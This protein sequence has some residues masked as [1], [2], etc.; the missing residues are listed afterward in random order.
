MS[1]PLPLAGIGAVVRSP[2]ESMALSREV[3]RLT[4]GGGWR[5]AVADER[6]LVETIGGLLNQSA[7]DLLIVRYPTDCVLLT[8]ALASRADVDM[9][10]AGTLVYW[11]DRGPWAGSA[12]P[13]AS[14]LSS[15]FDVEEALSV[16]VD[17]FRDY[18]NHYSYNPQLP[19]K[20]TASGYL[21]W[22]RTRLGSGDGRGI[23]LRD[24]SG[25]AIGVATVRSFDTNGH[26]VEVELAGIS[27]SAQS[28]GNYPRLWA[29][30]RAAAD[31]IGAASI[32]ISTQAANS[33]VQR[34]WVRLGLLPIGAYDTVH[35]SRKV[36]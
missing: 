27:S 11:E 33:P 17:S 7:A 3:D 29:L 4:I 35:L 12:T 19:E 32:L 13:S 1:S 24:D 10:S 15:A 9:L 34:A 26:V 36:E 21:E 5:S 16:I 14:E 28:A 25:R 30:V 18:R 8:R 22:A 6:E 20:I 31:R 23:T 2:S